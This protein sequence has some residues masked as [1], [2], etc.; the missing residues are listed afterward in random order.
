MLPTDI[1]NLIHGYRVQLC[2][3][4][5]HSELTTV[6]KKHEQDV[7]DMVADAWEDWVNQESPRRY[8]PA[9]WAPGGSWHDS[10]LYMWKCRLLRKAQY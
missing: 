2:I 6:Y 1:L 9:K 5:V 3:S 8:T 4:R 10:F 7:T